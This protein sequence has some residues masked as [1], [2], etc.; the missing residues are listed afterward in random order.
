M[1]PCQQLLKQLAWQQHSW[2]WLRRHR[3]FW[4]PFCQEQIQLRL[5]FAK[6][7]VFYKWKLGRPPLFILQFR[8]QVKDLGLGLALEW[9]G[10][11]AD[12]SRSL[13][14]NRLSA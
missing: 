4:D 14:S 5:K 6:K 10:G 8:M 11:Y 13:P 7:F 1:A 9:S 12:V 3:R 2:R